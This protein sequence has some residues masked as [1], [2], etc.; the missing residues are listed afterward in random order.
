MGE[1]SSHLNIWNDDPLPDGF[2]I[3]DAVEDI[4][5]LHFQRPT[6][7]WTDMRVEHES[8]GEAS[9]HLNI[10]NDDPLLDGFDID[11][12]VENI[13]ALHFLITLGWTDMKW[14]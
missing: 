10:W 3:D 8:L 14:E 11:D 7:G 2:D 9:S 13:I 12:A 6:F 1:A 5:A 4:I